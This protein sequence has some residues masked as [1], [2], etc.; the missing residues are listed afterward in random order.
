MTILA[1]R[2]YTDIR[3]FFREHMSR[4]YDHGA[5]ESGKLVSFK[6][7]LDWLMEHFELTMNQVLEYW[8]EVK[9]NFKI[10]TVEHLDHEGAD[11]EDK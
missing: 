8:N 2:D 10:A 5:E 11:T 6:L 1:P 3:T 9:D 7:N 4:H